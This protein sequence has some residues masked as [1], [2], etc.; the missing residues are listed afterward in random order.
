MHKKTMI[1]KVFI[2]KKNNQPTITLSRKELKRIDP[3]ILKF[4]EDVFVKL[5]IFRKSKKA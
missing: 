2:N 1:R 5:S 4:N 3:A